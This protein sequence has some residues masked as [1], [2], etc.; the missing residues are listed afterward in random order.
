MTIVHINFLL[1]KVVVW[2][3]SITFYPNL[4]REFRDKIGV[5]ILYF[6]QRKHRKAINLIPPLDQK[7]IYK[8]LKEKFVHF[9]LSVM[10]IPFPFMGHSDSQLHYSTCEA[11][12]SSHY[13]AVNTNSMA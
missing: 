13:K 3:S 1:W 11:S 9:L 8:Y 4:S 6:M 10:T 5:Q 2:T 7:N 12:K